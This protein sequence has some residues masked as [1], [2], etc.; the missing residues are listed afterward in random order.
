M[1][2]TVT[3]RPGARGTK[4]LHAQFGAEL[5]YVRYRYDAGIQKRLKTIEL[6]VDEKHWLPRQIRE[7][8][9]WVNLAFDERDLRREVARLGG[10]WDPDRRLWELR[11]GDAERLGLEARITHDEPVGA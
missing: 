10:R 5:M 2:R 3:L 4:T 9:V 1:K 8:P 6:V 7:M 11:F